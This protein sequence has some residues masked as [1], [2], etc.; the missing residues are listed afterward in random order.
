MDL[1]QLPGG[2]LVRTGVADLERRTESVEAL[3]VSMALR[4][5]RALGLEVASPIES[6]ELKLYRRLEVE[7]GDEAAHSRYNAL[8]RR[9]VSFIKTAQCA[10]P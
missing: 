2:D 1:D 6:P 8:R 10:T 9:L 7:L 5:L 3:L 4:Q